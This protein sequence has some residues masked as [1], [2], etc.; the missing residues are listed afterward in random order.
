MNFRRF[1][2]ERIARP[3]DDPAAR[4]HAVRVA[5]AALMIEVVRGDAEFSDIEREAVRV[6][7]GRKFGLPPPE[8]DELLALAEAAAR[9]AHD[10]YQF[11]SKINDSFS[12]QQKLRLIEELWR[13]AFADETLHRHEDHLIRRVAGLLHVRHKDLVQSRHR[14]RGA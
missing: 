8:A 4:E 12:E 2:R 9:D 10:Y 1:F 6:S 5:A 7:V 11:T 13:V 14:V 3:A